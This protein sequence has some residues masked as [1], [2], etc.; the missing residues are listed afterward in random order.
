[1][2]PPRL[3]TGDSVYIFLLSY[4]INAFL[5][6]GAGMRPGA[7]LRTAASN[8][9][10]SGWLSWSSGLDADARPAGGDA[11]RQGRQV[12]RFKNAST[13]ARIHAKFRHVPRLS[14]VPMRGWGHLQLD[15]TALYLLQLAQLTQGRPGRGSEPPRTGFSQKPGV[16]RLARATGGD[17]GHLER[18]DKGNHGEPERQR[19]LDRLSKAAL[20]G[21]RMGSTLY[22]PPRR[23][24]LLVCTSPS[25]RWRL[26]RALQAL[27]ARDRRGKEVGQ[28]LP[29]R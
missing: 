22:G 11:C 10:A 26:R 20:E 21:P 27:L 4:S 17:Y 5:Y 6:W 1:V 12:E 16:L 2:Y 14:R 29:Y 18:G 9:Q 13:A 24:Q 19:Q 25:R 7:G 8:E 28:C 23:R 15:A 3:A